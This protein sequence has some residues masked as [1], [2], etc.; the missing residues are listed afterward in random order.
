MKKLFFA[1]FALTFSFTATAQTAEELMAKFT[2]KTG[3]TKFTQS[4]DGRSSLLEVDVLIGPMTMSSKITAKYP[5][6]YRVE[7]VMP[8]QTATVIVLDTIAYVNQGGKVNKFDNKEQVA[9]IVPV[10][11]IIKL[12]MPDFS[13]DTYTSVVKGVEGKGKASCNVVQY[14]DSKENV[15]SIYYN[16]ASGLIDKILITTKV[17]GKPI[18]TEIIYKDYTSYADGELNLPSSL[19][20]K[21]GQGDIAFKIK[22]FEL[23]FPTASWM[24]A[25]P[26]L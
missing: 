8:N 17:E 9:Q 6:S 13:D 10:T 1:L 20:L 25:A 19:T 21:T 26:K 12:A 18:T 2:E 15:T 3:I 14:T 16:V 4:R 7:L 22:S 5:S 24:F 11:D 23:D